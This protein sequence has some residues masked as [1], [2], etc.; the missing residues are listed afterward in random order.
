ML[1][2]RKPRILSDGVCKNGA[3]ATGKQMLSGADQRTSVSAV[4]FDCGFG[5]LGHFARDYRDTFGELPSETL[6]RSRR[7][8]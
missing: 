2:S 3:I 5:N 4:A 7:A 6:L 1:R 8:A